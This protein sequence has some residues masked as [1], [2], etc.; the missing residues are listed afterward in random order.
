MIK[1]SKPIIKIKIPR[2]RIPKQ[3]HFLPPATF[4]SKVKISIPVMNIKKKLAKFIKL[5]KN[6]IFKKIIGV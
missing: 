5:L 6:L 1:R 2:E 4:S 3:R